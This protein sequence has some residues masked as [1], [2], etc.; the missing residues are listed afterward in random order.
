[1]KEKER[2]REKGRLMRIEAGW[3]RST[4]SSSSYLY[5]DALTSPN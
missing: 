5:E 2:V 4:V 3:D 1:M